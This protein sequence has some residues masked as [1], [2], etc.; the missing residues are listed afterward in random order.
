M[1]D[2]IMYMVHM[3]Y[4]VFCT[5]DAPEVQVKKHG[6]FL[7]YGSFVKTLV[8]M[9]IFGNTGN[10]KNNTDMSYFQLTPRFVSDSVDSSGET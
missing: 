6:T 4:H 2:I 8:K 1:K 5:T 3:F 7:L 9:S 10:N